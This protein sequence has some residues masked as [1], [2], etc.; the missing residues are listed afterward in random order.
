MAGTQPWQLAAPPPPE[1]T[2]Q[3][4]MPGAWAQLHRA[5]GW[6]NPWSALQIRHGQRLIAPPQQPQSLCPDWTKCFWQL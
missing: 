6:P 5:L 2:A 1:A 3:D 4:G